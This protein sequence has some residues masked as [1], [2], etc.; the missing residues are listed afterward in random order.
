MIDTYGA[1]ERFGE[2]RLTQ[3]LREAIDPADAIRRID[4]AL[5][6]FSDGP[7]RDDTAVLAVQR[8]VAPSRSAAPS[9]SSRSSSEDSTS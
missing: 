8:T 7:Q 4:A 9:G 3:V 2:A 5:T 1:T 6:A